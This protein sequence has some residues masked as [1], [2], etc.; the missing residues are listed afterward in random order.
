MKRISVVIGTRAQLVKMAPVIRALESKSVEVDVVISGQHADSMADLALDLGVESHVP[1]ATGVKERNSPLRL[2]LWLLPS[3]FLMTRRLRELRRGGAAICLVHGDTLSTLLGAVAAKMAGMTVAHV[4][5]GLTSGRLFAPFPEEL[6]RRLVFRLADWAF[7]PGE[8]PARRMSRYPGVRVV[9]TRG[10]TIEDALRCVVVDS[11]AEKK[12]LVVSLHR[13]ENIFDKGRLKDLVSG[14]SAIGRS[15]RVMFVLHPPTERQLRRLGFWEE[16]KA[17]PGVELRQR[18]PYTRF[19]SE[20]ARSELVITDG[21]SNQEE[22]AALGVPTLIMRTETERSDGIGANA[23]LESAV[24]NWV[25]YVTSG[26][27]K[28]LRRPQRES[29]GGA[30]AAIV[31]ALMDQRQ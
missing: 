5:S 6:T 19:I 23:V 25:D 3:F 13:Y 20:V 30:S 9:D 17:S 21:G 16:L 2:A 15:K 1:E 14:I 12:G 7:C 22:L 27:F 29:I 28:V 10:N 8:E 18:M 31:D 11:Q 26:D 24:H 4:E